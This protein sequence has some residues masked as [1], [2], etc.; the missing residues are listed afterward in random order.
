EPLAPDAVPV[1]RLPLE[2]AHGQTLARQDPR[3]PGAGDP[4]ADD[5]DVEGIRHVGQSVDLMENERVV[6]SQTV[7]EGKIVKLRVDEVIAADGHR[8][9]RE[10]IEHGGAVAIV[11][12]HDGDVWLVRQ[13]RHPPQ[14][15]LLEIPAGTLNEGEDPA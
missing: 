5:D 7:F 3:E 6:S 9:T 12:V 10:V 8:A 13:Y 11:C 14:A 4:A 15:V 1:L 2:D